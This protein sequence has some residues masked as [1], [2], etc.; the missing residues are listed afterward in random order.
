MSHDEEQMSTPSVRDSGIAS[1]ERVRTTSAIT[2]GKHGSAISPVQPGA[3]WEEGWACR[4]QAFSHY[5]YGNPAY[6]M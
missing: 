3:G 2:C 1:T 5:Y 6:A 4:V